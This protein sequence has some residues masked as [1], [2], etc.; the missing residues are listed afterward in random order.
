MKGKGFDKK[1]FCY[2][3]FCIKRD[4]K[5]C[6]IC[7][8]YVCGICAIPHKNKNYCAN[9]GLEIAIKKGL[10]YFDLGE[11]KEILKNVSEIK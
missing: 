8:I 7:G 5:K 1:V 6:V 3:L 9:C 11:Q 2:N 4:R 10:D